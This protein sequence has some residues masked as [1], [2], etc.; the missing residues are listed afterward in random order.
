MN[1]NVDITSTANPFIKWARSL[2]MAKERRKHG[3]I[4]V[5]GVK[6]ISY[7]IEAGLRLQTL[8]VAPEIF[9]NHELPAAQ[10]TLR[11]SRNCYERIAYRGDT[12]GIIGVFAQ[13]K[14]HL[15]HFK[16]SQNPFI[17]VLEAIEKP[18]N[19][20]AILRV[21][22]GAGADGVIICDEHTDIWNPNAIRASVGTIFSTQLAIA[23]SQ[24][25][26]DFLQTHHITP[27]AAEVTEL[28][29]N[30]TD[31]NF[32]NSTAVILGT[33]AHEVSDFWLQKSQTIS[34]PMRGR[35]SS[36]NVSA[37][38]AVLAYEALRQRSL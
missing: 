3:V 22:D 13:P 29:S 8:F 4:I 20:G 15:E 12:G 14:A 28:A 19:L 23:S 32:T 36:L 31:A 33:E 17:F 2:H 38:A 24:A 1:Q 7:A 21:T 34:L 30:Y 10:K 18:G 26:Y 35:N 9:G 25:T 11:I 16:L 5:E 37:T 6:E 27:L